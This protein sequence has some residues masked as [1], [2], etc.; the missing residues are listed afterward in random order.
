MTQWK[1]E[2]DTRALKE[3]KKLDKQTQKDIIHYLKTRIATEDS[4]RRFGKALLGNKAGLWRYRVKN[5]RIICNLEDDNLVVLV[6]RTSH[7]KDVYQL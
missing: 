5:Y 6:L 1:I 3:L 7:R 4:P 2:W